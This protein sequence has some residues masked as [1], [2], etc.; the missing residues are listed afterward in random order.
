MTQAKFEEWQVQEAHESG[1]KSG[2]C[3]GKEKALFEL[4]TTLREWGS[5]SSDCGCDSCRVIREVGRRSYE[6]SE[7][8]IG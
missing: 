8:R 6:G 7:R 1:Y 4:R 5:H 3:A 2:Y